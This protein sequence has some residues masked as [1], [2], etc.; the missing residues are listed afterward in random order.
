MTRFS[1]SLIAIVLLAVSCS[2]TRESN[3]S[4]NAPHN[5]LLE[6]T[7]SVTDTS[8]QPSL[9]QRE[10]E[11][12][13]N[14]V[15]IVR[16]FTPTTNEHQSGEVVVPN[17]SRELWN[18]LGLAVE[19]CR[20]TLTTKN[21][22]DCSPAVG[23]LCFLAYIEES[24]YKNS[25]NYQRDLYSAMYSALRKFCLA[26]NFAK[27]IELVTVIAYTYE[28]NQL[29][30]E[31]Y[32]PFVE[33]IKY[34]ME[35][36]SRIFQFYD[37]GT[38]HRDIEMILSLPEAL[39]NYAGNFTLRNHPATYYDKYF[40]SFTLSNSKVTT[41]ENTGLTLSITDPA[42]ITEFCFE[43]KYHA[44]ARLENWESLVDQCLDFSDNNCQGSDTESI[45]CKDVSSI[46]Q[47]ERLWQDLPIKCLP[48]DNDTLTFPSET[49][50]QATMNI[51]EY[52]YRPGL[53]IDYN[54]DYRFASH[55]S[56]FYSTIYE[57][58]TMIIES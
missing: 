12:T 18:T 14:S 43:A 9:I 41:N 42:A 21:F 34:A 1:L 6:T 30:Y 27:N 57:I 3:I 19:A 51:L 10:V 49:C 46:A 7:T 55:E 4:E 44:M 35:V 24:N 20:N 5:E 23:K 32:K 52:F 8:Q 56:S 50:R 31:K 29:E 28:K 11:K 22:F 37:I 26:A 36:S 53:L 38:G 13:S 33:Q 2:T 47:I 15:T 40:D 54:V 16:F 48:D 25:D 17:F 58:L 39:G 45:I